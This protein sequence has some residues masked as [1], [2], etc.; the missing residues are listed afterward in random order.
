[1]KMRIV[2]KE[3]KISANIFLTLVTG[4]RSQALRPGSKSAFC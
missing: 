3:K 1:M 2:S 4:V